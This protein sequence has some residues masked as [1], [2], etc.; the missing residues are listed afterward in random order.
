MSTRICSGV[1]PYRITASNKI[2]IMIVRNSADNRWTFP[3]GGVE[4]QL[5][6]RENALKEAF[7]EGGLVGVPDKKLGIVTFTKAGEPQE[8]HYY[9]MKVVAIASKYME[10]KSRMRK[11]VSLRRAL[12]ILDS[13]SVELLSRLVTTIESP[14]GDQ[15]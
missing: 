4:P 1:I 7:E 11:E 8:V 2:K 5:T 14:Q 15:E 6:K 10:H 13:S 12:Q 9:A 3:K